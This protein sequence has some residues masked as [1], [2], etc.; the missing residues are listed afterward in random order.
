MER[1][2]LSTKQL[3]SQPA[4]IQHSSINHHNEVTPTIG[5]VDEH[6]GRRPRKLKRRVRQ[7]KPLTV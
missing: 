5:H 4:T 7:R 6:P 2:A 1:R 3:H